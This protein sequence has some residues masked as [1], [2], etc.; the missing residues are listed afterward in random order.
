MTPS[1]PPDPQSSPLPSL[2][3]VIRRHGLRARRALG[4]NFLT[5][6][7]IARRIAHAAGPLKDAVVYE[8]GPGA[9]ALTRAVLAEAPSRLVA[10]EKD[11]RFLPALEELGGHYPGCLHVVASD[12][13]DTDEVAL[14]GAHAAVRVIAN[15]PYNIASPLLAKWLRTEPWP[16]WY[17]SLTLMFQREVATRIEAAPGGR[18]YGRLSVLAQWRTHARRLF[19]VAPTAF[20]PRPKV[21]SSIIQLVPRKSSQ[22]VTPA[23]LSAVL[24]AAFGQRRKMLRSSLKGLGVDTTALLARASIDATKRAEVLSVDDFCRLAMV[25]SELKQ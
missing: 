7:N 17:G 23:A 3:A 19:D 14:F 1:P 5:D 8:V 10:V 4:Q 16:P 21:T 9:G 25:F 15:L 2:S 22:P 12:A 24:A 20:V 6:A 18:D 13:L 11:A